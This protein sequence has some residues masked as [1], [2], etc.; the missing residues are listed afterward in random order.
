MNGAGEVQM[1]LPRPTVSMKCRYIRVIEQCTDINERTNTAEG[2]PSQTHQI[3]CR[4]LN[5]GQI[6]ESWGHKGKT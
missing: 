3:E 5:G 6:R 1:C 2:Q 4:D